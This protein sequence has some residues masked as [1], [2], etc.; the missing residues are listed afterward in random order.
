MAVQID[1]QCV[2]RRKDKRRCGASGWWVHAG[3]EGPD[4]RVVCPTCDTRVDAA[5]VWFDGRPVLVIE[6][7]AL[8]EA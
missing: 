3:C 1:A 6:V 7:H 5:R 2:R 4:G 8:L